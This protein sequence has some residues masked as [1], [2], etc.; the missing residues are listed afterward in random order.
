M[1]SS[2]QR[3]KG[4]RTFVTRS[5]RS[6]PKVNSM[7]SPYNFISLM[8]KHEHANHATREKRQEHGLFLSLARHRLFKTSC[9]FPSPGYTTGNNSA[10]NRKSSTC[11]AR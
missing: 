9:N 8:E 4:P 2:L 3:D 7:F 11:R 5:Q 1:A 6:A 10:E